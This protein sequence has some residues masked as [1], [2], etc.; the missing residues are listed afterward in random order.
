MSD[1]KYIPDLSD[2]LQPVNSVE[3]AASESQAHSVSLSGSQGPGADGSKAPK[4]KKARVSEPDPL[5][6]QMLNG[7]YRLERKVGEGGMGNVYEAT[8]FPLERKVAIKILKPSDTN[9][10][11]EHYFMREVKAI[12]ML[13]HPNIINV[14]DFG[15]N[16]DGGALFL[17]MEFLPGHTLER[18]IKREF[19]LEPLRVCQIAIQ[20]LNAL[21]SAHEAGIVHCDL[22]PANIMLEKVAGQS[23]FVKVL[24]FGIAK[25][26]ESGLEVGPYTQQGNIVGTFDYMSPEQ[27]MRKDLD[28]RSDLWS[29]GVILYEMLTRKRIFHDKDAVSIIGRV[30][31]M[32]LEPP[33]ALAPGV[34]EVLERIV[35]KAM[36]R[37]LNA[38]YQSADQ[39]RRALQKA[40]RWLEEHP[41]GAAAPADFSDDD[42]SANR[43]GSLVDS[44]LVRDALDSQSSPSSNLGDSGAAALYTRS[45]A[46]G[47]ADRSGPHRGLRPGTSV[48]P[49]TSV[50]D[51]TFSVEELKGSLLG[52]KR[53]VAVLAIRQR[54]RT[55]EGVEPAEIARRSRQEK[56]LITEIVE[57]F[58]GEVDAFLGGTFTILFGARRARVGDNMRA[59]ECALALQKALRQLPHGAD[60]LGIG[61]VYGEVSV[62]RSPGATAWGEAIDR[63]AGVAAAAH[64][65]QILADQDL[66]EATRAQVQY[67]APRRVQG[68]EAS[69]VLR[70][71]ASDSTAR[72][73]D[74]TELEQLDFFVPRTQI[75]EQ[76]SRL[77]AD[78]HRGQGAGV[79]LLGEMG[80]G[81]TKFLQK[82]VESMAESR[83]QAFLAD[84]DA[85]RTGMGLGVVRSWVRQIAQT[86]HSPSEL[87]TRASQSMGL[88]QGIADVVEFFMHPGQ[89]PGGLALP[90]TSQQEFGHFC[91]ALL[92]KLLRYAHRQ[93]AVLLA[94]DDVAADDAV[95]MEFLDGLIARIR[96][97]PV[98]LL[99]TRQLSQAAR[100]HGLPGSFDVL[101]MPGFDRPE[102]RQF[103]AQLMGFTPPMAVIE[104]LHL[105]SGGNPVF[106]HELVRSVRKSHGQQGLMD[107]ELLHSAGVPLS[108]HELLAER[109]DALDEELRDLLRLS[110]VLGES[111]REAWF[112]QITPTH[113]NPRENLQL[114]IKHQMLTARYDSAGRVNLAF[115]PRA[116]R[117]IVYDRLPAQARVDIHSRVIEFLENSPQSAAV[118]PIDVPLMLAFHYRS[119]DSWEG[120]AYYLGRVGEILL[121][122]YDYSGAIAHF[123]EAL[124]LLKQADVPPNAE[125]KV[126]V[127]TRLLLAL[128]ESGR[129][130]DAQRVVDGLGDVDT[131]PAEVR[132]A[133]LYEI[134]MTA[135][136]S[137]SMEQ[138]FGALETLRAEAE[139]SGALKTEVR[140]LLA[141]AQLYEKQNQ[142]GPAAQLLMSV[143]QKVE[144]LGQ[145]DLSNP[146]DRKL[147]WTAYNQLGTL[148]IRQK[149]FQNAQKFLNAALQR[150]QHIADHRGLT[151]VLSNLGALCL[152]VRDVERAQTYFDN[153]C[154]AAQGVGDLLN[155]SRIL[156]NQG[157][158]AMQAN[159][160][161][162]SKNYF[163]RARDIA[164]EIGWYEG[165]A[166]LSIHINRLKQAFG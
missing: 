104:Q 36:E 114:L 47:D 156:T 19:P 17:V 34:P 37:N 148:F 153:A 149:D 74:P 115:H 10:E 140:A 55:G 127:Q 84:P 88:T 147:Y 136:E 130:E 99:V 131:M 89:E 22:K 95:L 38:R 143:P 90:W 116:L 18:V 87:I 91:A 35:M 2:S 49:G 76:L 44:A 160:L 82:F 71:N 3:D 75:F 106:L 145:L 108:L 1:E 77:A 69:E 163:K 54:A 14:V 166:D 110:S 109:V 21:E 97:M 63:A 155:L 154:K 165:L 157:I 123:E 65:A 151:R 31:Q 5:I 51:Q 94:M 61:L 40:Q 113:L 58:G 16:V 13:R 129:I 124:T 6:G 28:G 101:E 152:S 92:H 121:D 135:M 32:P 15:K 103:V 120:A 142:L 137:G 126:N 20:V 7:T 72:E 73:A 112:F 24:D 134:G 46:F 102:S 150:A 146:E 57:H 133:L 66:A 83:W 93:G 9:P 70:I 164:E 122:Q 98:L 162:D 8:Q 64:Q 56:E 33:S 42:G 41:H 111:F 50:L 80:V 45:G 85:Q 52:E 27:I 30:M 105:R 128:R 68:A 141:L 59:I 144:A 4:K 79:A 81:K 12:N 67:D 62:S 96:K 100:D 132:S 11:G 29:L 60:H 25:V 78:V 159:K 23:D 26:K 53:K 107:A 118:D 138:S 161:E 119:V 86:Y 117:K 158:T 139:A 39:M 125:T 48:A 43:S